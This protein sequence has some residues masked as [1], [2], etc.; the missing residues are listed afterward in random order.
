[1]YRF[2]VQGMEREKKSHECARPAV[3]GCA[4]KKRKQQQSRERVDQ[5][6]RQVMPTALHS[7]ELGIREM[8]EPGDGKPIGSFGRSKRPTN[9]VQRQAIADVRIV[10]D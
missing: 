7:K 9:A 3:V 4:L 5:Y 10:A 2:D 8:G 1:G 6:V